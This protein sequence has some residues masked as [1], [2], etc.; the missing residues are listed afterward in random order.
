MGN[1]FTAEQVDSSNNVGEIIKVVQEE[2]NALKGF[3]A[4]RDVD[5]VRQC[6]KGIG[7]KEDMLID[8]LCNRTKKQLDAIDLRYHKKYETSLLKVVAGD[9]GGDFG[10]M[11]RFALLDTDAYG[12]EIFTLATKGAGTKEEVLID[13]V[14]TVSNAQMAAIKK[15]WEAKNNKSMLDCLNSEL[16]GNARKLMVMLLLGKKSESLD[17]DPSLAAQQAAALH[18]AGVKKLIGTDNDVFLDILGTQSR[19]QIQAIKTEYEQNYSMSLMRAVNKSC[20][21]TYKKCLLACLFPT[22]EAYTAYALFKAFEGLGT[23][24]ARVT[25]LLGGTDKAKMGDVAAYYLSSYGKSLVEDLKDELSGDFLKAARCWVAGPDPTGGMEY[26]TEKALASANSSNQKDLAKALLQERANVK[27]FVC[28]ADAGDIRKACKGLGT[29]DSRLVAI[30]CGR[31]KP[32]LARVDE[33]YHSLFGM[34]MAAQIKYECFGVY[35]DFLTYTML[36]EADFDALM[37]KKAMDGFG[38]NESL[39]INILAPQSNARILA[40]KARHDQKYP[41]PLIDRLKS[42]LSGAL[43]DVV[44]A[45]LKGQ[46]QEDLVDESLAVRQAKELHDAGIGK[47][48]GTDKKTFI[49]ILTQASRPQI[50]LIKQHY[51]RNHGMS[52]EKAIKKECSG[53]FETILLAIIM[54]PDAYYALQLKEAFKGIGSD[55]SSLARILGGNDKPAIDKIAECYRNNYGVTLMASVKKETSGKLRRAMLTWVCSSDPIHSSDKLAEAFE[56]LPEDEPC[57]EDEVVVDSQD[58]KEELEAAQAKPPAGGG[59]YYQAPPPPPAV[60]YASAPG[61]A[62]NVAALGGMMYGM[63]IQGGGEPQRHDPPPAYD[64]DDDEEEYDQDDD[65]DED[66]DDFSVPMVGASA[67]QMTELRRLAR[68]RTRALMSGDP[69]KVNRTQ[70]RIKYL[71][72]QIETGA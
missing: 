33:Y 6:T 52:L 49:R 19:A 63:G 37:L 14:N 41:K 22:S 30:V 40:A 69:A 35:K 64:G 65:D 25:R 61:Y 44:V 21:G 2:T 59:Q 9:V 36:P 38:T 62:N 46:R 17:T 47:R 5:V 31:T 20:H 4:T 26:V 48:M 43:E 66:E 29:N 55:K 57:G 53:Y 39:I 34:S 15:K 1:E 56:D 72:W 13:L 3:I 11:I 50:Q 68:I 45:L 8:T 32:H 67:S 71:K 27:D 28:Q 60:Y 12:A 23:D 16:S 7:T 42:E 24:E 70:C 58:R 10:K 51:E 18:D 54:D